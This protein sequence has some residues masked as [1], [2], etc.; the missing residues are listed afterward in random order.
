MVSIKSFEDAVW[1]TETVSLDVHPM[2]MCDLQSGTWYHLKV[3][4]L[5]TAGS[6]TATY[7]FSTLTEDGG[8]GF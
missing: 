3:V 2:T 4:A 5:T 1:R 8:K 7:Y 6:S